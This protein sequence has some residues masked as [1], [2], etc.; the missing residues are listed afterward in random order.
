MITQQEYK[1]RRTHLAQ[2]LP[3]QTAAIIPAASE[4]AR[5]GDAYYRFRQNSDFYYLSGFN[6]PEAL[7]VIMGG[8]EG[9]SYLFNRPRNA[10]L[11]QWTGRRLG[12]EGAC[13]ELGMRQA[14]PIEELHLH[15]PSLLADKNAIYYNLNQA[16]HYDS[17]LMQAIAHLKKQVRRG[18]KAPEAICS[19]DSIL[20]EMRLFKSEAEIG[21]MRK[22]AAISIA[23]HK[24]AMSFCQPNRSE[25][26]LE[27]EL[28][29]EF[30]RG[31][32]RSPAYDPIVGG[33]ANACILHYTEN[34]QPLRDGDLVLIDAGGEYDNY[35]A[36]ITRT[37]PVN[38]RFTSEQ[39]QIYE[40]VLRAQK[41]GIACIK[42]GVLWY[43]VQKTIVRILTQGLLDLDILQGNIDELL[44]TEAYSP[45][46][47]HNSG[48]WLGLDVHDCGQY[49][50]NGQWRP[51]QPGMVL[52]VEPGLYISEGMPG[53]DS[54]WWNIGIRIEDDILVT[55]DG[56]ENL[57]GALPVEVADIEK[58]MQHQ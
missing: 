53:V 35:A 26:E 48:H 32:C 14:Y 17:A 25:H 42:P 30:F 55:A 38:G 11:E 57:T 18:V 56:S 16:P 2:Q 1:N 45:F 13:R 21:L 43:D 3:A 19:L 10:A 15:L 58:L 34:N 39:R 4:Q 37:F 33:G 50:I 51:L 20:S 31:G 54:K 5:N 9:D 12:Q 41:A 46:Y 28:L 24:R 52:T 44:A 36:D 8:A 49:K 27:A 29:Y 40:L 6:E 47:M 7:L 23:A 22:A